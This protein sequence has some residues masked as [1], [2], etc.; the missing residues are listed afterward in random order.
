[1]GKI[2]FT[3]DRFSV[4]SAHSC[5][6]MFVPILVALS[7]AKQIEV[8]INGQR[9]S[10]MYIARIAQEN[11]I[12]C[13]EIR[14]LRV[15]SGLFDDVDA[16]YITQAVNLETLI[17]EETVEW[18]V[19]TNTTL[20][21]YTES[22]REVRILS[23]SLCSSTSTMLSFC[24]RV[25]RFVCPGVESIGAGAFRG[26]GRGFEDSNI[27]SFTAPLVTSLGNSSFSGCRRLTTVSIPQCDASAT[28]TLSSALMD[29]M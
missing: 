14:S 9:Y 23:N 15:V 25:A 5:R 26:F 17:I 24:C 21:L 29:R 16:L 27:T 28:V 12:A 11:Q 2:D 22:L 3:F 8:D 19:F 4:N 7:T 1:M 13:E 18:N 6:K 10:E 20:P